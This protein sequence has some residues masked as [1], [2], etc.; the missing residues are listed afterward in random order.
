M[1]YR[2]SSD[3]FPIPMEEAEAV[4]AAGEVCPEFVAALVAVGEAAF[5]A[6]EEAMEEVGAAWE[7]QLAYQASPAAI[8]A[9]MEEAA[10]SSAEPEEEPP[11]PW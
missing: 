9:A 11:P 4:V 7:Y 6:V 1:K 8:P 5:L 2:H 10:A 3:P